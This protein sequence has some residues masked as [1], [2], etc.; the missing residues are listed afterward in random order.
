MK[1]DGLIPPE[2]LMDQKFEIPPGRLTAEQENQIIKL[3]REKVC[4]D[5]MAKQLGVPEL[6]VLRFIF[7]NY[8]LHKWSMQKDP[9]K[10]AMHCKVCNQVSKVTETRVERICCDACGSFEVDFLARGYRN[11]D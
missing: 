10:L 3:Y 6:L 5:D 1:Y 11:L 9:P 7:A 2:E 8:I 4:L